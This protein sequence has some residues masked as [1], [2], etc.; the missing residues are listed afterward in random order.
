MDFEQARFN[1]VE[2]QIRPWEV[3]DQDVLE[4]L[5]LVKREL[6]VA[7]EQQ[8]LAFAEVELPIGK[9]Q[10]MW[11]PKVEGKAMQALRLKSTDSVL[12]IGTGSGFMAA[13]LAT[14]AEW[15]RTLEIDRDLARKAHDNLVRAGVDNVIV[16]E[17]DGTHGWPERAPYDA[18]LASGAVSEIPQAWLDQLKPGGR[19][20]AFVGQAPVMAG[21]LVTR[22]ADG[23]YTSESLFEYAVQPLR[24]AEKPGSKFQF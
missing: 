5:M 16:E 19:L 9:G 13:L 11:E 14:R 3:L 23:S 15:V 7:S 17:A 10:K 12:E 22:N 1:M 4:S 18:I 8:E 20:F 6:F 21:T 2:Q 24:I